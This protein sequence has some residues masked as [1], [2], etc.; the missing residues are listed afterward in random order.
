[1]LVP[2]PLLWKAAGSGVCSELAAQLPTGALCARVRRRRCSAGKPPGILCC[3]P[4]SLA[5]LIHW[6]NPKANV[7]LGIQPSWSPVAGGRGWQSCL[8]CPS[9]LCPGFRM[10]SPP[11]S[12]LVE[13]KQT[14]RRRMCALGGLQH[15]HPGKGGTWWASWGHFAGRAHTW[16]CSFCWVGALWQDEIPDWPSWPPAS[17]CGRG[18]VHSEDGSPAPGHQRTREQADP[19]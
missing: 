10:A 13:H 9:G 2:I 14:W 19:R 16:P 18:D 1:M 8:S 6:V 7:L 4:H 11:R 17:P 12:L 5:L 15:V 3:L